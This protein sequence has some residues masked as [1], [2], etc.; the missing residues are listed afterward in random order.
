MLLIRSGRLGER[1]TMTLLDRCNFRISATRSKTRTIRGIG[2]S[3]PNSCSLI[4]VSIRVPM[5]GKCRTARR[6]HSLGSPTLTKVAV[7]TVATGT[8]SR[9]EGGTLTYNVSK[10]LSGPVI[11]RR[12]VDALRGDLKWIFYLGYSGKV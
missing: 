11:V 9:S 7:L 5:V 10:F 1:V 2:G 3:E 12:L 8:F 6:V 4:L